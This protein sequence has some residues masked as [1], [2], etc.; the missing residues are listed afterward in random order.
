MLAWDR[1]RVA[2]GAASFWRTGVAGYGGLRMIWPAEWSPRLRAWL[3]WSRYLL[4]SLPLDLLLL[5]GAAGLVARG[6]RRRD[7]P[8]LFDLTL[9][10]FSLVYLLIHWLWAFPVWDRYLLPLV[11]P[12]SLLL[13][14]VVALAVRKVGAQAHHYGRWV[15]VGMVVLLLAVGAFSAVSGR[16]PVGGGRDDYDGIDQ[17]VAFLRQAPEGTVL[18]HHWLGW[19]YE[20]YLF[21]GPL[22]L[23]YWPTPAWL[24]RDVQAFGARGTRYI[25]FP[26]WESSARA[27]AALAAVGYRLR[28]VME[29]RNGTGEVRFRLFQV[30]AQER[31]EGMAQ[32]SG[33]VL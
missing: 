7:W 18:Y 12:V 31:A 30:R 24:A 27:E 1:I 6:V 33:R 26:A 2:Q 13:G 15:A 14:R 20:F 5:V 17:V 16:V 25:V 3:G 28:L 23:A 22:Y 19:E 8:A 32:W 29:A 10:G 21:D 4:G 9:I 11:V